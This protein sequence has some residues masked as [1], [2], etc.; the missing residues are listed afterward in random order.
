[1]QAVILIYC[2]VQSFQITPPV[3][4]I[5]VIV[6]LERAAHLNERIN[7]PYESFM[8]CEIILHTLLL[9]KLKCIFRPMTDR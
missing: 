4:L 6:P 8:A 9:C 3:T 2:A 5:T 7:R 1:M